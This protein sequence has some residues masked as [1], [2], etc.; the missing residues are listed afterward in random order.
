MTYNYIKSHQKVGLHP[1]FE[2]YIYVKN[3]IRQRKK[4][5]GGGGGWLTPNDERRAF[6]RI[7]NNFAQMLKCREH[8]PMFLITS[9]L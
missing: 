2:K 1:V 8:F 7:S 5:W 9:K 4:G 3:K 6:S